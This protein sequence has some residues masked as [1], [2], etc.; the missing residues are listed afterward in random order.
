MEDCIFCKII[1]GEVPSYKI[2]EDDKVFSFLDI[3][4]LNSGHILVLSKKHEPNIQDLDEET[5]L[6]MMRV[7]KE[8][9]K[10]VELKLNPKRVGLVVAGWDVPHCHIHVLPMEDSKDITSKKELEGNRVIAQK[11][12]LERIQ[13]ILLE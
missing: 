6:N 10:K 7:A 1:K 4:P 5:Y 9:M 3:R 11:E 13:K 12:E 8:L 2:Y